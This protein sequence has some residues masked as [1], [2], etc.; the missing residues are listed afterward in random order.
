[1]IYEYT[2]LVLF[3]KFTVSQY[4]TMVVHKHLSYTVFFLQDN[5]LK[6]TY[7]VISISYIYKLQ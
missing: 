3:F 4:L 7:L 6:F 2:G 1:M 5:I